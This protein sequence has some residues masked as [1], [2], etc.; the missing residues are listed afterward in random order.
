MINDIFTRY[1]PLIENEMRQALANDDP[2]Y[3]GYYGML[4]YH[5]GWV[6]QNFH[7]TVTNGGKRIRPIVCL[8]A[9][10]AAGGAA[11][12]ALPAAAALELLH[13]FSLIHDDVEDDSPTRRHRATVWALWGVPQAIN[14]GDALFTLARLAL[15]GLRTRAVEPVA[16]LDAFTLFDQACLRLTEGQYLDMTFEQRLDVTVDEYLAMI[17]GKTAALLSACV[18]MGAL[19]GGANVATRSQLAE[20]GRALGLAFQIEDDILGIWGDERVTGKSAA[21]DILT[22][23][24]SLP[25]VFA[26]QSDAVGAAMQARYTQPIQPED[27]PAVLAWLEQVDARGFAEQAAR[28]AHQNALAALQA[29]GVLAAGN[30]GGQA[31]QALAEMLLGR[32][33]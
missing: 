13:N 2:M 8:L 16:F 25:V 29:S 21:I 32:Q 4:R 24:K 18:E 5:M 11:E 30:Q 10:E 27:V 22:R 1:L 33:S 6:D 19:L 15:Q 14:A 23:K 20:F 31:L 9:C 26:L 7:P 28:M 12:T 3:A 17:G